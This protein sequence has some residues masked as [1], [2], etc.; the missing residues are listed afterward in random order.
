MYAVIF[1]AKVKAFD[2]EYSVMAEQLRQRALSEFNCQE[3]VAVTEGDFEIAISY[4]NN[5]D[6]I[7]RWKQD[8]LHIEA[9]GKGKRKW[10]S[11]YQVDVVE[12]K[13]SYQSKD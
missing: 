2:D 4:W 5:L 1:K 9:Q 10:Y 6:D 12:V 7:K 3:F 11:S 8:S 13:R